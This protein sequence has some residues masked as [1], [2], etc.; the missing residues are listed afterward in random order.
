MRARWTAPPR[1]IHNSETRPFFV[2]SEFLV[3]VLFLMG[4]GIAVFAGT[5]VDAGLQRSAAVDGLV[6]RTALADRLGLTDLC[7]FTEARYTRHLS[8]ADLHTAF[9]D[10]PFSLDHFPS[11]SLVPPPEQVRRHD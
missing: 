8:Q 4:L 5:F 6:E 9:Q 7:L 3:F 1:A 2:T 10:H 11:G